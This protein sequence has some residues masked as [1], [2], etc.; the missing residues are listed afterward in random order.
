MAA[1]QG[2][3]DSACGLYA[4]VNALGTALNLTI[5]DRRILAEAIIVELDPNICKYFFTVGIDIDALLRVLDKG[6]TYLNRNGEVVI[7]RLCRDVHNRKDSKFNKLHEIINGPGAGVALVGVDHEEG[8]H[9]TVVTEI[10]ENRIKLYDSDQDGGRHNKAKD[11]WC[12]NINSAE[13]IEIYK[14]N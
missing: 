13:I 9:W 10:G 1:L 4:V 14:V 8:G 6:T 12:A 7:G 5:A 11:V 2:D 3:L